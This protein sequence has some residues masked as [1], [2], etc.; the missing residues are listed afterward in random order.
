M[1]RFFR[2]SRSRS[3]QERRS[4]P[5]FYTHII[6]LR[7]GEGGEEVAS[8]RYVMEPTVGELYGTV[9]R[10]FGE[11]ADFDLY[12]GNRLL[13]DGRRDDGARLRL[14]AARGRTTRE[15]VVSVHVHER[16]A[17][18]EGWDLAQCDFCRQRFRW[19]QYNELGRYVTAAGEV[20]LR[21]DRMVSCCWRCQGRSQRVLLEMAQEEE[22]RTRCRIGDSA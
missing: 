2:A 5:L 18:G 20:G 16:P 15:A 8:D 9:S 22:E 12:H 17:S 4:S 13:R 11:T 3:P 6:F 21:V 7:R 19:V 10:A 1:D 14:D